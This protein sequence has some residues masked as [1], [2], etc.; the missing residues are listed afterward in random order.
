MH[1]LIRS[2]A[3]GIIASLKM[4]QPILYRAVEGGIAIATFCLSWKAYTWAFALISAANPDKGVQIA[5]MIA[6]VL[7]PLSTLQGFVLAVYMKGHNGNGNGNG[8][9]DAK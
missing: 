9:T 3:L 6:S 8:D 2:C 1:K 5:A 4:L 7:G